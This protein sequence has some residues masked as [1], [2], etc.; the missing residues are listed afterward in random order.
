[1]QR[2][3][4]RV[5]LGVMLAVTGVS[6]GREGP[7]QAQAGTIF[8]VNHPWVVEGFRVPKRADSFALLVA[9]RWPQLS[10]GI[11]LQYFTPISPNASVTLYV[12]PIPP[13]QAGDVAA[14]L[15]AEFEVAVRAAF[16]EEVLA[17][18]GVTVAMGIREGAAIELSDGTRVGGLWAAGSMT[19]GSDQQ[20][21]SVWVFA[22]DGHFFKYRV[23][24]PGQDWARLEPRVAAWMRATYEGVV[25]AP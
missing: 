25:K 13:E 5:A 4:S 21:S 18:S 14:A 12:Y 1:M 16:N 7:V 10:L 8:E 23:T 9:R 19:R 22:K 3:G 20:A 24:H 6:L 15:L 17:R 2:P 11:S